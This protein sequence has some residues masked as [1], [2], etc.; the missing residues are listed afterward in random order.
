MSTALANVTRGQDAIVDLVTGSEYAW[1]ER[2]P[3]QRPAF[4]TDVSSGSAYGKPFLILDPGKWPGMATGE[5][6]PV[7]PAVIGKI[8]EA[9]ST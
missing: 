5:H 4:V 8:T 9:R 1:P 6:R 3:H 7:W 2:E